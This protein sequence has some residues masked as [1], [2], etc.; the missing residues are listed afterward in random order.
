DGGPQR[1]Q[2]AEKIEGLNVQPAEDL[3]CFTRFGMKSP[4]MVILRDPGEVYVMWMHAIK[5]RIFGRPLTCD[6]ERIDPETLKTVK[7]SP[8][9]LGGPFW[10]GGFGIHKNGDL[11]VNNGRWVH[12]LDPDCALKGSYKLPVNL[13]YN[14]LLFLDN[15]IIVTK[16]YTSEINS[17]ISFLDP[18]TLQP[19]CDHVN[20]PEPSISRI[21]TSGNTTYIVGTKSIFRY[22]WDEKKSVPVFDQKWNFN[23][24][25]D[26]RHDFGWDPVVDD[27]NVWFMDNGRNTMMSS[28]IAC[29]VDAGVNASPMNLVR[30]NLEDSS[31]HTIQP[32]SGLPYGSCTNPPFFAPDKNIFVG[33]DSPNSVVKAWRWQKA[34]RTLDPLWE[35]SPFCP[36]GHM[37]YFPDSGELVLNDFKRWKGDSIVVL[38]LES[39]VEK[40]RVRA[41][42][43]AQGLAFSAPGWKRDVYYIVQDKL[44][45]VWVE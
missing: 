12:R 15:G 26:S 29:M 40:G 33:Y 2:R 25:G 13:P 27:E 32:V 30:V 35:K 43:M 44:A 4:L 7:K 45:R 14:T 6:I 9:L 19:V 39:G 10:A 22:N 24:I 3:R 20:M 38:D 34:S 21:S 31:D 16:S 36:G 1:L 8:K 28:I 18:E 41:K 11:Y 37:L 17:V 42:N 5:A 23:Y